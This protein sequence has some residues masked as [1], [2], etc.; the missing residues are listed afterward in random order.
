MSPSSPSAPV[1]DMTVSP[2]LSLQNSP[3]ARGQELLHTQR[4]TKWAIARAREWLALHGMNINF[5]QFTDEQLDQMFLG[6]YTSSQK[7]DGSPFSA[8][9]LLAFRTAISR[10]LNTK[11]ARQTSI[12][13]SHTFKNSNAVLARL[14]ATAVKVNKTISVQD[15]ILMY[16][17]GTLS[18]ANPEGL[19]YKVWFE[20]QMHFRSK[21]DWSKVLVDHFFFSRNQSGKI[22]VTWNTCGL[23]NCNQVTIFEATGGPYCPV[24]SLRIYLEHRNN[25]VKVLLQIPASK[26]L[27]DKGIWYLPEEIRD[28]R[29]KSFMKKISSQAKL[30]DATAGSP[31]RM[32]DGVKP[33]CGYVHPDDARKWMMFELVPG[34]SVYIHQE[35]Y[36]LALSKTRHERPDGKAMA[37]YLMSCFWRQ[38]DLVGASIAEP[39]KPYQKSL[40][41]GIINAILRFCQNHSKELATDIRR[42]IQQKIGYAKFY[43]VKKT[44]DHDTPLC[45]PMAV[46]ASPRRMSM[47]MARRGVDGM[48]LDIQPKASKKGRKPSSF[49]RRMSECEDLSLRVSSRGATHKTGF[50]VSSQLSDQLNSGSMLSE[51]LAADI[52]DSEDVARCVSAEKHAASYSGHITGRMSPSCTS[53]HLP[54]DQSARSSIR[55]LAERGQADIPGRSSL[56]P[57][58]PMSVRVLDSSLS[59]LPQRGGTVTPG[60]SRGFLDMFTTMYSAN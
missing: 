20:L 45:S 21:V 10:Y 40:D 56:N 28:Y 51:R 8:T 24:E 16:T 43:F 58:E 53:H 37:R 2:R 44:Q 27:L 7:K 14:M 13:V 31:P 23:G 5:E 11:C 25:T 52:A 39:P 55:P 41:R 42:T 46:E 17:T 18:C 6:F 22:T 29:E 30:N 9:A 57:L 15:I 4:Q 49:L 26:D 38:S 50:N 47:E 48:A 34:S 1:F 3:K 35:N 59:D 19:L 33:L 12:A 54:S 32:P 60:M 36:N